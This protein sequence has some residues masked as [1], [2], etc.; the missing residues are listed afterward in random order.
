MCYLLDK[1]QH[2]HAGHVSVNWQ[3]QNS[4]ELSQIAEKLI[5]KC[6]P[7]IKARRIMQIVEGY[8]ISPILIKT[9]HTE[10][11][12]FFFLVTVCVVSHKTISNIS[13]KSSAKKLCAYK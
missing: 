12:S 1:F 8:T 6:I 7:M 9:M 4:V 5:R 11:F 10:T 2:V 13:K 3:K